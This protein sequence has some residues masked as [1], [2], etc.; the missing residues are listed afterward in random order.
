MDEIVVRKTIVMTPEMWALV[1]D[2]RFR[3]RVRTEGEALKR[4][5]EAGLAVLV[6]SATLTP[7]PNPVKAVRPAPKM[8]PTTVS[9]PVAAVTTDTTKA[10]VAEDDGGDWLALAD[11]AVPASGARMEP[12][13]V[14]TI[15]EARGILREMG[16]AGKWAALGVDRKR[17]SDA[18]FCVPEDEGSAAWLASQDVPEADRPKPVASEVEKAERRA[19]LAATRGKLPVAKP[20]VAKEEDPPRLPQ[21]RAPEPEDDGW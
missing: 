16:P 9:E 17:W 4:L 8:V 1:E 7:A 14:Y 20:E 15:E 10:V 21:G 5:I 3:E 12:G 13:S 11:G 19:R 6:P 2:Y 18:T